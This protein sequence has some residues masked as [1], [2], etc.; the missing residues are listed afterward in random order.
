[1]SPA[2]IP[3]SAPLTALDATKKWLTEAAGARYTGYQVRADR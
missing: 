3:Q 1:M 2:A